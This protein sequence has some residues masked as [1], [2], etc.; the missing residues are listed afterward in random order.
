MDPD[1]SG[2]AQISDETLNHP[3]A[4]PQPAPSRLDVD[5]QMGRIVSPKHA[6][7]RM[8]KSSLRPFFYAESLPYEA[9]GITAALIAAAKDIDDQRQYAMPELGSGKAATIGAIGAKV[10]KEPPNH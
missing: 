1:Y 8:R 5:M 7:K 2:A 6:V 3:P 9:M 4:Y 10:K